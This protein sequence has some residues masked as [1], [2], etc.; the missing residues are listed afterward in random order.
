MTDLK[1]P[2]VASL[3][4][5][6]TIAASA[7]A[8]ALRAAGRTIIDLGAGELG[9]ETPAAVRQAAAAAIE[10]GATRYT[11]T[12][13]ILPLREAIAARANALYAG[14]DPITPSD[15]VVTTGSKQSL[16]N[17]CFSLFGP[18]DE[19]LIPTPGW[20]SYEQMVMLA[21]ATPV[22]VAG[23]P[24]A[25]LKA[26][27]ARIAAASTPRTRGLFLNSPT[28]PTGAV[29]SRT[30][31]AAILDLARERD[32]WVISDEIYR[33]LVYDVTAPSCLEAATT[34]DRLV[35]VDGVAKA[36]AMT[37]WRIG[38]S[39]APAALARTMTALQSHVTSNASTPAQHAALAALTQGEAI[40]EELD[41]M[42]A[43]LR[44]RRAR[45][46]TLLHQA[47]LHFIE[48]AGAFY[49]FLH[50]GDGDQFAER[51]LN[52]EGVAVVPGS[53]FGTPEWVRVSF[54]AEDVEIGMRKV[55]GRVGKLRR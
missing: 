49:V 44:E 48:P 32:W 29:H 15:I 3:T 14:S 36:Y 24:G 27:P 40:A 53:A 1:G 12:E 7:R 10:A 42:L 43:R 2:N 46:L 52:E 26:T 55:V 23:D 38:W 21:R 47:G 34:R 4:A 51:L 5:S 39:L 18:G 37:G 45:C 30:E 9:F 16:F 41:E 33:R 17:A 54:A 13:G 11:A 50:V 28:N 19:V 35:I 22:R 8:R 20:T 6:A 31:L 25:S